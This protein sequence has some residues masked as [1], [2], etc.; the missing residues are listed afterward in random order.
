MKA[1]IYSR[2]STDNQ[3][4]EGTSLQTQLEAC[5]NYCQDKGYD[6]ADRFTET[7]SGLTLDRPKLNELRE[8]VGAG[9]INV[10][11]IY[12]LDR[13]SRNATHGVI[14]RDELDKHHI[15]LESVT[16][17]ID[18]TPLGEAITYLRGTFS[19]LEAEKIRERTMRGKKAKLKE[20]KMP[21]GTGVGI[22]GYD[23]NKESKRRE[24]K[25]N[26]AE[27]VREIFNMVVM[28]ES[29]VSIARLLNQRGVYTKGTRDVGQRKLWHSLTLRRMIRNSSYTGNT[30]FMNTV[31]PQ[32]TP[33]IVSE[34]VFQMAN[35]ELDKPKVRTGRPKNEYL[36]RKHACCAICGKP[37]VGHC[38]NRKYRY[39][40][41]SS[42]RPHENTDKTCRARLVRADNLE[43]IVWDK[44]LEVLS[45]G[46]IC[47]WLFHCFTLD[48]MRLM[49]P[50]KIISVAIT[51]VITVIT[52][53]FVIIPMGVNPDW[54]VPSAAFWIVFIGFNSAMVGL[55][56]YFIKH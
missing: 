56:V 30:Y 45:N 46:I 28:G 20:G 42:S 2:V 49:N 24:A 54:H 19:Q 36:L 8:L 47:I 4:S 12:C 29:L 3:E 7:Y 17:D 15:L 50:N 10:V 25:P 14:L 52:N 32:I 5:N 37:L 55:V 26:E 48:I 27:I 21:Q 11:V 1:A 16:E 35:A 33:P 44:T 31:L 6:V 53:R 22:Y 23:W 38:L 18:K 51:F 39:Y 13:L 43:S 9:D 34:D 40:Q 41:C